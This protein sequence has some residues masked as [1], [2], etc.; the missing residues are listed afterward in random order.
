MEKQDLLLLHGALGSQTQFQNLIPLLEAD[1]EV[2][3]LDFSS[4]GEMPP[5]NEFGIITFANEV[6]DELIRWDIDK[7]NVFGYSMG[8]YVAMYL[9]LHTNRINKAF[10]LGTKF[11]WTEEYVDKES[12]KLNPDKIL[13]K[14]PAFAAELQVRHRQVDWKHMLEKTSNMMAELGRNS[15][16]SEDILKEINAEICV[17]MG[18]SD[19][20]VKV[21]EAMAVYKALAHAKLCILPN[22]QHPFEKVNMTLLA[23]AI[24]QYF[25][26]RP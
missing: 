22:T 14:V 18:D 23:E 21:E 19:N 7:I 20:T 9:A 16:L 10:T 17:G 12:Q 26:E 15:L 11:L 25:L 2:Y 24:K 4:H 13:E 6:L 1:F 5:E 3:T 8:G